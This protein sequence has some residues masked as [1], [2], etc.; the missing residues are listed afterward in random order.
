M[1]EPVSN[2]KLM[3]DAGP[4]SDAEE[5]AALSERLRQELLQSDV[6]DVQLVR[7]G[8]APAGAKGDPVTMGALAISL[9]PAA[10]TGFFN[11]LQGW[12]GRH[13]K[14]TVTIETGSQKI[15]LTGPPSR[16]Q[17]EIIQA[18]IEHRPAT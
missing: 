9:A 10:L 12:M 3:I 14:S 13:D 7:E 11:L 5:T 1:S 4:D 2:L 18:A 17:R 16:E 8:R 15:V 6:D